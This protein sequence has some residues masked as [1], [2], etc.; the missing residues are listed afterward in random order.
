[1]DLVQW[2]YRG[3]VGEQCRQSSPT[4]AKETNGTGNLKEQNGNRTGIWIKYWLR[5]GIRLL[6]PPPKLGPSLYAGQVI[7][8]FLKVNFY[9]F[10]LQSN[11]AQMDNIMVHS[12]SNVSILYFSFDNTQNPVML[13]SGQLLYLHVAKCNLGKVNLESMLAS[14]LWVYVASGRPKQFAG[15]PHDLY[16]QSLAHSHLQASFT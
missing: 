11:T 3:E 16:T 7:L 8:C 2:D 5:N 9:C 4:A 6:L 15:A 14:G 10:D 13:K 12:F 1:M